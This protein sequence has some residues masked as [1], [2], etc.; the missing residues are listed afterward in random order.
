[1]YNLVDSSC[2]RKVCIREKREWLVSPERRK[3]KEDQRVPVSSREKS[4]HTRTSKFQLERGKRI[5]YGFATLLFVYS[6]IS[7]LVN[8]NGLGFSVYEVLWMNYLLL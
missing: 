8:A 6:N 7:V 4:F 3:S 1:M 5:V 2:K